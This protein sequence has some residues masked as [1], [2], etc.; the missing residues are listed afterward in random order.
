LNSGFG[1]H[2]PSRIIIGVSG[3]SG[4]AYAVRLLEALRATDVETHLLVTKS[5]ELTAAYE[6]DR[7]HAGD[8]SLGGR[9]APDRRPWRIHRLRLVQDHGMIVAPC[10]MRS[11]AEIAS[12]ATT[13]LLARAADVCLKECE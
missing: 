2:A 7:P 8:Q 5:G 12:G 10:S 9:S 3:A 4:I 13:T 6:H 11:L 1:E